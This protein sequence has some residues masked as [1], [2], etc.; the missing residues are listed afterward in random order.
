MSKNVPTPLDAKYYTNKGKIFF[1]N[2]L[3]FRWFSNITVKYSNDVNIFEQQQTTTTTF[4]K[5]AY[6]DRWIIPLSNI[7]FVKPLNIP[8]VTLYCI[9]ILHFFN[10]L[11]YSFFSCFPKLSM[12]KSGLMTSKYV[13]FLNVCQT[14]SFFFLFAFKQTHHIEFIELARYTLFVDVD[15]IS[16]Y[17]LCCKN[18]CCI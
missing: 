11:A 7:S 4:Q 15:I 3:L 16:L 13:I 6:D 17:Y 14:K 8:K 18:V 1:M 2:E 9:N 12:A 10:L 5:L